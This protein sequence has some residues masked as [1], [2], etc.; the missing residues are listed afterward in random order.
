[1][2]KLVLQKKLLTTC[3]VMSL[4]CSNVILQAQGITSSQLL[5]Q[6]LD[7]KGEPLVAASVKAIHEPSGTIYGVYTRDDGRYNIPNMRIGGP[8][9]ITISYIGYQTKTE[10][11][12]QLSLGQKF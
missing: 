4:L 10:T 5:G 8:Y 9:K 3:F 7:S 2:F 6:I 1:M 12:Q 11:I